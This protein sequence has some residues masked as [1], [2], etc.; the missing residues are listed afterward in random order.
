VYDKNTAYLLT[1]WVHKK[2]RS[3]VFAVKTP[4]AWHEMA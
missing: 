1:R 2:T 3:S 4:G